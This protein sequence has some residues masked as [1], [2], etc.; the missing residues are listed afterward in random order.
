MYEERRKKEVA[1]LSDIYNSSLKAGIDSPHRHQSSN[2]RRSREG[3]GTQR[4]SARKD[5]SRSGSYARSGEVEASG[6]SSAGRRVSEGNH[7]YKIR[8]HRG[9]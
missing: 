3:E 6:S 1:Y 7:H 9:Q 2:F 8:K 5:I 4:S